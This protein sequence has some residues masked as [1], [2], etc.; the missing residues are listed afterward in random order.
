MVIALAQ[1]VVSLC[2]QV[3]KDRADS[4]K[5]GCSLLRVGGSSLLTSLLPTL[6]ETW[7]FATCWQASLG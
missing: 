3:S 1:R 7:Q 2:A 5:V 6:N 4:S